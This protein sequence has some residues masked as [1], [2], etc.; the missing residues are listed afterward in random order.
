VRKGVDAEVVLQV[1]D[2]EVVLQVVQCV[3]LTKE[4]VT[5]TKECATLNLILQ[6]AHDAS[7]ASCCL[8]LPAVTHS[9]KHFLM[10]GNRAA[11]T[12]IVYATCY[13]T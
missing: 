8:L 11:R 7:S 5:L 10:H 12:C 13:G 1:V 2:A 9:R 4:C 6:Q 3:T